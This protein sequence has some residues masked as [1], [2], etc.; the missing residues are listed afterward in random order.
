MPDRL[1]HP[2]LAYQ[3][4]AHEEEY[5]DRKRPQ[6]VA[7][8]G[9]GKTQAVKKLSVRNKHCKRRRQAQHVK[10]VPPLFNAAHGSPF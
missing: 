5:I 2:T 4:P 10:A 1:A 8:K 3:I 6:A 9:F 7:G